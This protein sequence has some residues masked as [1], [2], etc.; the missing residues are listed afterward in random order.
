MVRS[1][2]Y[3]VF[4][5]LLAPQLLSEAAAGA[6]RAF[7]AFKSLEK[8]ERKLLQGRVKSLPAADITS[9]LDKHADHLGLHLR[10]TKYIAPEEQGEFDA[11][12]LGEWARAGKD[13][14][15]WSLTIR[16][17]GA[18]SQMILFSEI[19]LHGGELVILSA[20][21]GFE[22][23]DCGVNCMLVNST[24]VHGSGKL[25]SIPISGPEITL[26]YYNSGHEQVVQDTFR[27]R[28]LHVMQEVGAEAVAGALQSQARRRLLQKE[29]TDHVLGTLL[30]VHLMQ[31][32]RSS[33]MQCTPSIVC[34]PRYE[35]LAAGVVSI[36]A[37]DPQ[38][39]TIGLCS[40][41]IVRAPDQT[42]YVLTADHCL[43]NKTNLDGFEFWL[44]IFNYQAPCGWS[45]IPPIHD[46]IQGVRLAY[47][48]FESDVLLLTIPNVIPDHFRAYELG[49]DASSHAV[50]EHAIGIHHPGGV[51]TAI[52]TV[53][54][55]RTKFPQPDFPPN[56]VQ[57][58]DTNHLQVTW[59]N[60]ATIGGSSGSP[61]IN[62]ETEKIVG[63]LTGGYTSCQ[64]Q[65]TSDY[66]GTLASCWEAGLYQYL[67]SQVRLAAG[68]DYAKPSTLSL[69]RAQNSASGRNATMHGPSLGVYPNLL[70]FLPNSTS[71]SV[72]YYLTDPPQ[73]GSTLHLTADI[74][75]QRGNA[76]DV[77][78]HVV[79]GPR[80]QFFTAATYGVQYTTVVNITGFEGS[81]PAELMRFSIVARI[82]R[83]NDSALVNTVST[84]GIIQ[85]KHRVWTD[86]EPVQV[87]ALPFI[88]RHPINS[89][90]GRAVFHITSAMPQ[91]LNQYVDVVVCLTPESGPG[92]ADGT[93]TA[94][95]DQSFIWTL[96]PYADPFGSKNCVYIPAA[97]SQARKQY[98]IVVS[99]ADDLNAVLNISVV[100]LVYLDYTN[101]SVASNLVD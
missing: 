101:G 49:F 86:F 94:Y 51:P 98:T 91:Q 4:V 79:L 27:L 13:K 75:S 17:P 92:H 83:L 67:S 20:H 87:P 5:C 45:P 50:P 30:P 57:P 63:V 33:L 2:L 40:G 39:H 25:T 26:L 1:E 74:I 11:A 61:L 85:D 64:D 22:H 14:W 42:R 34:E 100:Q 24:H 62:I 8:R 18:M 89:T 3:C 7:G 41:S 29:T 88:A 56:G 38:S 12:S 16:S 53:G 28:I 44:I 66:Y 90:S 36:Y 73:D 21:Q 15:L 43:R 82:A 52:S 23:G 69:M 6:T 32:N 97:L 47:Y 77:A 93:V 55:I 71:Q 84:K 81:F 54:S 46:V 10:N 59:S 65:T 68:S 58:T 99:D 60:G 9:T 96:T 19:A 76:L 95:Q 31:Q 78:Q 80:E 70:Q 35:H 48:N 72:T 37:V